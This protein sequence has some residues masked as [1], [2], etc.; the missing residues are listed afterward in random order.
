VTAGTLTRTPAQARYATPATPGAKND[1]KRIGLIACGMGKPFM[2][3]QSQVTTAATE[4]DAFGRLRYEIVLVTVPRQ[5]GKTTLVGPVQ[6]DRCVTNPDVKTFY[7]A[8]TGKDARSRFSD[9]VTLVKRS[10]LESMVTFRYSAGD[11]G[12]AFPNGSKL[13]I[14]APT[15]S[16]IHGETPPLVTFDE[17]W[18]YDEALGDAMLEDAVFPAQITLGGN[19]QVWM[20]STAGTALSTFMKKWV[21]RGRKQV[22]AQLRG[23]VGQYPKLA[24]FEWSMPEGADP[25]NRDVLA[26]FHPAVG[27]TITVDDLLQA[28]KNTSRPKWLRSFCNVW[29][30]AANTVMPLEAWDALAH[31]PVYVPLRS[32]IVV[33]YEVAPDNESAAVM[34]TWRDLDPDSDTFGELFT[35]VLHAAPGTL[36]LVDLL[37]LIYTEW[38][39]LALGA[40]DGGETRAITDELR[41][42]LGDEDRTKVRTISATDFGTACVQWLNLA[43]DE[44]ALNHDGSRSLRFAIASLVLRKYGDLTRFSRTHST[45]SIASA[46]A[47][48]VGMWLFDHQEESLGKPEIYI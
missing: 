41:R 8:Q 30:E 19:R 46:I 2:P 29:T 13:K 18:E 38:K 25:Y 32:E 14:F 9:L 31:D 45:G 27:F 10:P 5:S 12:I 36:W 6:I 26:G 22:E 17:I 24:Y 3:W 23:E 43:R 20:I 21:D 47:S 11:E 44:K 1:G 15:E 34:A 4:R 39:P 7:T 33:T 42:R 48:A 37:V 16:A 40:D 28:S 35:R